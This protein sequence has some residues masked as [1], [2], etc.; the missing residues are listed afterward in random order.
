M[1]ASRYGSRNPHEK[2]LEVD[3]HLIV[4]DN[5]S[6]GNSWAP[7]TVRVTA[8]PPSLKR[9]ERAINLKMKLP[10]A[11]FQ[12]AAIVATIDVADTTQ[13]VEIDVPAVAEAV[14]G[15]IGMDI[16]LQVVDQHGEVVS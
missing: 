4:T 2:T 7:P 8:G 13:P 14:R 6:S 15:A 1:V 11:L 16:D 12:Q 5:G 10:L 3:C 9:N